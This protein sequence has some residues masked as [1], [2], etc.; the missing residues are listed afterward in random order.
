MRT[1]AQAFVEA[2]RRGYSVQVRGDGLVVKRG[3]KVM[4]NCATVEDL[5]RWLANDARRQGVTYR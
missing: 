5:R 1:N 2:R 3:H 4:A